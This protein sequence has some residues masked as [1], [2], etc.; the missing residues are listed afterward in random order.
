ML[1][2]GDSALFLTREAAEAKLLEMAA[3]LESRAV[4]ARGACMLQA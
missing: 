4:E 1:S 2:N 3:L